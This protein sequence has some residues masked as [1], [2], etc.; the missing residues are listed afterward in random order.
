M[1]DA[2]WHHMTLKL[3]ITCCETSQVREKG[4]RISYQTQRDAGLCLIYFDS[5]PFQ[6]NRWHFTG[7]TGA[8]YE[9][10]RPDARVTFTVPLERRAGGRAGFVREV[11]SGENCTNSHL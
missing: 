2:N 6:R 7:V 11:G 5:A 3:F 8:F 10:R 4:R 9:K 1:R